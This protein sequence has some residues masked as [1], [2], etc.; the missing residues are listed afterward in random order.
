MDDADNFVK[1]PHDTTYVWKAIQEHF[2]LTTR[3]RLLEHSY[4]KFDKVFYASLT[5]KI[6]DG[7]LAG[8]KMCKHLFEMAGEVLARHILAV[9]PNIQLVSIK[10]FETQMVTEAR[11]TSIFANIYVCHRSFTTD[12]MDCR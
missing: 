3:S 4:E 10:C 5:K 11:Y 1:A 2:N 12:P 7:A 9:S 8:D 6:S